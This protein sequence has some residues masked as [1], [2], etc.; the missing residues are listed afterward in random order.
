MAKKS[1]DVPKYSDFKVMEDGKTV[2]TIRVK[3]TGILW[4]A[5]N[6]KKKWRALTIE[7]FGSLAEKHGKKQ[8]W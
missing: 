5:K 3:P 2:G 4:A 8:D 6:E 1:F 7:Q